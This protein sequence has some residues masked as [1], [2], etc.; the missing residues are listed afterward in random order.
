MQQW[1]GHAATDLK[2]MKTSS[3]TPLFYSITESVQH[4]ARCPTVTTPTLI[5]KSSLSVF[6]MV[7]FII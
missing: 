2:Q 3:A 5:I 6:D 4:F 7:T 1:C